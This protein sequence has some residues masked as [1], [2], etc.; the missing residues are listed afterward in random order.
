MDTRAMFACIDAYT[1][2]FSRIQ[3]GEGFIRF[4]D[5]QLP[6]MYDHNFILLAP[7]LEQQAAEKIIC[8]E[9]QQRREQ[10]R[11]FCQVRLMPRPEQ[12]LSLLSLPLEPEISRYVVC[13]SA[14][15]ES[16]R[17]TGRT[18]CRVRQVATAEM[19][20]DLIAIDLASYAG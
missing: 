4:V 17:L 10:G 7:G 13:T 6:D 18:D 15:P 16:L 12:D 19:V 11:H 9:I 14:R 20:R 5:E 2:C 1:A 3:P 8:S